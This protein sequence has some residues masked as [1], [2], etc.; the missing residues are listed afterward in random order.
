MYKNE[1]LIE[2]IKL[3]GPWFHNIQAMDDAFTREISPSPGPQ[4]ITPDRFFFK[5][6]K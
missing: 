4:P 5:A 6:E 2:Q 3:L 1:E